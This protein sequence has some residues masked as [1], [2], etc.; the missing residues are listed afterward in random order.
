MGL[1]IDVEAVDLENFAGFLTTKALNNIAFAT[2]LGLNRAGQ[3]LVQN[4]RMR[5][6]SVFV[7]R[8]TFVKKGVTFTASDKRQRPYPFIVFGHRDAFIA[9]HEEGGIAKPPTGEPSHFVPL[10]IRKNIRQRITKRK[11]PEAL[12][13]AGASGKRKAFIVFLPS[14]GGRVIA[15]RK[16]KRPLPLE[17]LYTLHPQVALKRTLDFEETTENNAKFSVEFHVPAAIEEVF[18]NERLPKGQRKRSR[19]QGRVSG[20]LFAGQ[21]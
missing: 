16:R 14:V 18:Q 6:D 4:E 5:M 11:Q 13:A 19:L 20:G 10:N 8:N 21:F 7:L 17:I 9:R 2:S 12:L 1:A 15:R 3:F